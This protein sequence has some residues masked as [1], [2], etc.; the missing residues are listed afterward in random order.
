MKLIK[1]WECYNWDR[2]ENESHIIEV[3]EAIPAEVLANMVVGGPKEILTN[4]GTMCTA[5]DQWQAVMEK[6]PEY[7]GNS[8]RS[9]GKHLDLPKTGWINVELRKA[10]H[11]IFSLPRRCWDKILTTKLFE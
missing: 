6:I 11:P 5:G 1:A 7:F 4:I 2:P 3:L 10:R 8:F 9:K